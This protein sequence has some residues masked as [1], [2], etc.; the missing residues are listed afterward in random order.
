MSLTQS[1]EY[2]W[3]GKNSVGC[4]SI[5]KL[6]LT[7]KSDA[8]CKLGISEINNTSLKLFP[9]PFNDKLQL[10]F[11][12]EIEQAGTIEI[13]DNE[14][15]LIITQSIEKFEKTIQVGSELNPGNYKLRV[16][17]GKLNLSYPIIKN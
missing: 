9:N 13:F 15:K 2:T 6:N 3:T 16:S 17:R 10:V 4:D 14:G 11:D 12:S 5:V 1:G 7:V 8:E